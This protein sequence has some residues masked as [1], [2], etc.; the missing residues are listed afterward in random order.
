M[1]KFGRKIMDAWIKLGDFLG[2]IMAVVILTIIYW[3]V[4]GPIA[5]LAKIVRADFLR[6]RGDKKSYWLDPDP[7]KN[8][9]S[10]NNLELP[11]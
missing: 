11:Y 1:R 6:L 4:V 2:S 5:I 7:A 8:Q 10:L 9:L 3:L